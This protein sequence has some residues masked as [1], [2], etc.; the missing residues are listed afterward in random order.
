MADHEQRSCL[1]PKVMPY[2]ALFH[3]PSP[4]IRNHRFRHWEITD[5][6]F[7]NFMHIIFVFL[8]VKSG[9]KESSLPWPDHLLAVWETGFYMYYASSGFLDF[10]L[11]DEQDEAGH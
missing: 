7:I 4:D 5:Y 8:T 10:A 9:P 11:G 3:W 2:K 1:D 6:M